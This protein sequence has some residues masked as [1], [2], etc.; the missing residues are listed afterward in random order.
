M[1][2]R[3][4]FYDLSK[5]I[6]ERKKLM[7]PR[8]RRY[9]VKAILLS[10]VATI[11]TAMSAVYFTG[12][13]KDPIALAGKGYGLVSLEPQ[14]KEYRDTAG[15]IMEV[16]EGYSKGGIH[17]VEKFCLVNDD[18]CREDLPCMLSKMDVLRSGQ[19][20]IGRICRYSGWDDIYKVEVRSLQEKI[21]L[22]IRKTRDMGMGITSIE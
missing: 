19:P 15:F 18:C 7:M 6:V 10:T 1:K 12:R 2:M 9:P 20:E 8:A 16:V 13:A 3:K 21:V 14:S 5:Q 22:N 4:T 17:S 11:L